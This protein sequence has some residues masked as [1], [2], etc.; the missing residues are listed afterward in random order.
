MLSGIDGQVDMRL[1]YGI[2]AAEEKDRHARVDK[3]HQLASLSF[4]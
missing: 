1:I 4:D 3:V 2:I